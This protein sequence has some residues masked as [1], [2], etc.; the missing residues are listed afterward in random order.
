MSEESN[1][2]SPEIQEL[3]QLLL[4]DPAQAERRARDFLRESPE[5]TD[6]L[7]FLAKSL[8]LQRK[9]T[10]ARAVLEPLSLTH[11][12]LASVQF[13]FGRVLVALGENRRATDTL[14]RAVE[15]DPG[16]TEAW[17]ALGDQLMRMRSKK[18]AQE[19]YAKG[20]EAAVQ[21]PKLRE[22]AS[23]LREKKFAIAERLAR[24][25]LDT[26]PENQ[27]ALKLLAD[28]ASAA[29]KYRIAETFYRRCIEVAPDFLEA[30][31]NYATL[32]LLQNKISAAIAQLEELITREP[33]QPYY[34]NLKAVAYTRTSDFE[35]AASEYAVL[36]EKS[37]NQ[38]AAWIAYGNALNIIGNPEG[39]IAAYRK[40]SRLMPGVGEAYW[41]LANLKT[42]HFTDAELE[43]MRE[44]LT[45]PDVKGENRAFFHFAV[46]KALEDRQQYAESFDQYRRANQ[47]V[48]SKVPYNADDTT[49]RVRRTKA[50]FT[51]ELFAERAGQGCLDPDPIFIVGLP[52]SGSTLVEQ[53]LATHSAIEGTTELRA[54]IYLA[55]RLG[56]KK[57]FNDV[58]HLYP[59][60]LRDLPPA[61][62]KG[63]GE[64]Y[65]WRASTHRKLGRQ[66]FTDKMPNNFAHIGLIQLILPNAKII[67]VRRHPMGCCFSS[68]KQHFGRD[69]DFTY[70]MRDLGRY[71]FDYV[72][73][74]AHFDQVLPGKVHRVF[75]EDMIADPE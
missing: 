24:E 38:P 59:E 66:H 13:E 71:Y 33:E 65:L 55:G 57:K 7:L 19:A 37:P 41:G 42:F 11:P 72:E 50:F 10:S 68:Y 73:L 23:A 58:P 20:F 62:L 17:Q 15:L 27:T 32:L 34:R 14:M 53:I 46:G 26:E 64:E 75:Y 35:S 30:R 70:S 54:I 25:V 48:R 22:A 12:Q 31:Y 43:T 49:D 67:D 61:D 29:H 40:A 52:R 60:V 69:Q 2:I 18:G 51:K 39:A 47:L 8:R 4:S 74:M 44:Q 28:V 3:R 6:V 56:G 16:S 45:R 5:E 9:F 36:L 1:G 21:D 63:L